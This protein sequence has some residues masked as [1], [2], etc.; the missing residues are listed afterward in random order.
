MLKL[1]LA[2]VD[3]EFTG[4]TFTEVSGVEAVGQRTRER[5]NVMHPEWFLDLIFGLPYLEQI[6][7]QNN[8]NMA[9]IEALFKT[10]IRKSLNGE[11]VLTA[12]KATFDSTSRELAVAYLLEDADGDITQQSFII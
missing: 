6:L 11:A 8:P 4:G 1:A 2:T 5:V 10:E 12:L 3:L 7:G 9:T